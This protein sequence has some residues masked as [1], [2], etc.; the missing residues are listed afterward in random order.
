MAREPKIAIVGVGPVGGV[1]GAYLARAGHYVVLCDIQKPHLDAIRTRGLSITGFARLTGTCERVAYGIAELSRFPAVDTVV[2]ATKASALPRLVPEIQKIARPRM[3]FVSCQ[4]GLDNEEFLAEA[5]GSERVL[6]IIVNY[7]G[8]Q[9]GDGNIHMSFFNP[10]NYI[11]AM[12]TEGEPLARR[13]ADMMSEAELETRF[14][15]QVK[16][17][18]WEKVIL[19]AALSAMCALTRKPMKDMMDFE[20]T[21]FLAEELMR[22]GI[23]V[24][25]AGGV[26]LD[27]GFLEHGIEYLRKAGYHRTSMH[28]DVLRRLPTE[29]DWLNGRIVERGRALGLQTPYN[30]TITTLIKGLEIKSGAPDE[31]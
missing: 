11:G 14:T 12:T 31:H 6:R 27:E 22:E 2:I 29:I 9:M 26:I 23:Q 17:Y 8:S 1:L 7:A 20:Q 10:P 28:Q 4:N 24:A 15:R 18:E 19:N 3:Q 21:A 30:L 5:F 25:E 13:L 16:K